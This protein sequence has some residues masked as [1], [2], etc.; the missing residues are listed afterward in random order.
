[1]RWKIAGMMDE[2]RWTRALAEHREVVARY[3]AVVEGMPAVVWQ[4]STAEGK[5]SPA[6]VTKHLIQS[7]ELGREGA[8]GQASMQMR[9]SPLVAWASRTFLLPLIIATR[10]FPRGA[11]APREVRPDA[12]EVASLDVVGAMER[13]TRV[14]DEAAHALHEANTTTPGRRV[15]HAY[16]GDMGMYQALRLLSAH[17]RH[18]TRQLAQSPRALA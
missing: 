11:T 2:R 8:R 5:W 16:F 7:Y 18:H 14:A 4:R 3:R 15:Q 1:M 17:T 9:T 13:L 10:R 12:T 6:A